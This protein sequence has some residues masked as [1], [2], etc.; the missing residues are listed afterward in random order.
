ME[1]TYDLTAI[2][3]SLIDVIARYDRE[4]GGVSMEGNPGGAPLNV[5]AAAG[6]LGMSTAF[7]GKL[8]SDAF[9]RCLMDT[10]DA[11]GIS[12]EGIVLT[13][14][15]LTT[16]AMVTLDKDG[17]RSFSFYRNGTAD[18][19][20]ESSEIDRSV[21]D[22]SRILHFGSVSMT[23]EPA[24]SATLDA[25]RYARERGI[26]VSYDPN[27]RER[28]WGS[29]EEA[30][31]VILRGMELADIVKVSE[32]ELYFLTGADDIRTGGEILLSSYGI[33][34]LAVT[35]GSHGAAFFGAGGFAQK[36][37]YD[38][39]KTIDTTGA[40]DAFW[41]A[42]LYCILKSCKRPEELDMGELEDFLDFSN[43]AGSLSTTIKGAIPSLPDV[44]AI[45]KLRA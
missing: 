29:L 14:S 44:D 18:V 15:E 37:T 23:T 39:V 25:A 28:L 11:C 22:R 16:L 41:G 4:R 31:S 42:F 6:K 12:R 30:K 13:D 2:G 34:I 36:P 38:K 10:I 17:D 20:L 24:R 32:E 3:E 1:K 7:I 9:G 8:S 40:G 19:M 26:T 27:L 35:L 33:K 5:L 45:E 43:A 21:I